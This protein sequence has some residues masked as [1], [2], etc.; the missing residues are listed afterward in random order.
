ML[1]RSNGSH[2]V[3][4]REGLWAVV[5]TWCWRAPVF[6][7]QGA[8]VPSDCAGGP[9]PGFICH[10]H[11]SPDETV[12]IRSSLPGLP[13]LDSGGRGRQPERR[14]ALS[15]ALQPAPPSAWLPH[16]LSVTV[17]AVTGWQS[18]TPRAEAALDLGICLVAWRQ[19][20][21][22]PQLSLAIRGKSVGLPLSTGYL[23]K[24]HNK[25]T[26]PSLKKKKKKC[27]KCIFP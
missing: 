21:S 2:G 12:G 15:W 8:W 22:L 27:F 25:Y 17:T 24:Q 3:T 14:L 13:W 5:C 20:V 26:N 6:Q 4:K 18:H 9:R 23:E 7:T 10:S 1:Q 19:A 16:F 11:Q